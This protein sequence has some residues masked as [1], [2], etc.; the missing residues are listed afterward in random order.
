MYLA[1]IVGADREAG[2]MTVIRTCNHGPNVS[3]QDK[4][5]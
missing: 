4:T 2:G 1:R 3:L 5:A